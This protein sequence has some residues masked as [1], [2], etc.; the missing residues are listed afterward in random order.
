MS[1]WRNLYII[2]S[3]TFMNIF[4]QSHCILQIHVKEATEEENNIYLYANYSFCVENLF[5]VSNLFNNSAML[6]NLQD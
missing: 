4:M 6:E 3:Q 5:Q 2:C 1:K